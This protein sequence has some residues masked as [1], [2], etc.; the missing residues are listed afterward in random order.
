MAKMDITLMEDL[1][2]PWSHLEPL[3]DPRRRVLT[4]KAGLRRRQVAVCIQTELWSWGNWCHPCT[5]WSEHQS[6]L[7]LTLLFGSPCLPPSEFR[8]VFFRNLNKT[9]MEVSSATGN[10][11][12]NLA[13]TDFL[14]PELVI[15][16]KYYLHI[17]LFR[18]W[19]K[20]RPFLPI[21]QRSKSKPQLSAPNNPS[22]RPNRP[23]WKLKMILSS[24][25]VHRSLDV[26]PKLRPGY[27]VNLPQEFS[28]H[29]PMLLFE[30][31]SWCR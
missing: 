18:V 20:M 13:S 7:F 21:Q 26:P 28:T 16:R 3:A 15:F 8:V 17:L 2:L 30:V 25:R 24:P 29:Q 5:S 19:H 23:S 14:F 27:C 12:I 9:T 10:G 22:S 1:G 31:R 6:Q 4:P 11:A